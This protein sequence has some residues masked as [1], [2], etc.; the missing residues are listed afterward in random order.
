MVTCAPSE[1][2][3]AEIAVEPCEACLHIV[4]SDRPD[5][6]PTKADMT[7]HMSGFDGG[8]T[9]V[10]LFIGPGTSTNLQEDTRVALDWS[11]AQI[12]WKR[13]GDFRSRAERTLLRRRVD[14]I[15]Q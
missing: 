15:R 11:I 2:A 6:G 3:V 13:V 8:F 9:W 1:T 5:L 4:Y 14:Y 12:G 7:Q 10:W